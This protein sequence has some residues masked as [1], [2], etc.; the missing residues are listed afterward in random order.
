MNSGA[1]SEDLP[2]ARPE[3]EAVAGRRRAGHDQ[4]RR[5]LVEAAVRLI[6]SHGLQGT[7]VSKISAALGLTEMAAYRH[8]GSKEE[9]L[10]AAGSY[11]LDRIL[12]WLD[13]STKPCVVGRL[14][15]IGERHFEMLSSDLD[16]YTAPYMQ[17]LT[18][19]RGDEPL[20]RHVA[21]NNTRMKEK[22]E[23]LVREGMAEGSIRADIDP[24]LFTH[25]FV[26][27]FLAEDIH[28]L[29]DLRDGTFSR[30][31]HLRMLDLILRD[32]AAEPGCAS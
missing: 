31:S 3:P 20:H 7:T 16:M 5:E 23:A 32:I 6:G 15:E 8:F 1:Q 19:T 17:F 25:E 11:L 10:M 18:M 4:R 26:G 14:R 2:F 24:F 30:S 28:C 27:W 21:E 12:E 13:S 29:S 9:I 22:I